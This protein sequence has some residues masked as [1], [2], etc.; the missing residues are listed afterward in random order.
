MEPGKEAKSGIRET[1]GGSQV[2]YW[3]FRLR[4]AAKNDTQSRVA[5]TE[6]VFYF[7]CYTNALAKGQNG[8]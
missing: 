5:T 2:G 6:M 4:V 1:R 7:V 8:D 3:L